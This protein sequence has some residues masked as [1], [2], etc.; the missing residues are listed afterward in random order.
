MEN[1][2]KRLISIPPMGPAT[3]GMP[4]ASM[5]MSGKIKALFQEHHKKFHLDENGE[6]KEHLKEKGF[7]YMK[8][9]MK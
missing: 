8:K 6:W 2:K 9:K 3:G 4:G 7:S 1:Q 5:K